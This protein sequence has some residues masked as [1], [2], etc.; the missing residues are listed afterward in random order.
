MSKEFI[1]ANGP[2]AESKYV[3]SVKE[4]RLLKKIPPFKAEYVMLFDKYPIM[5]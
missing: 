2:L 3:N 5:A 1:L 4:K